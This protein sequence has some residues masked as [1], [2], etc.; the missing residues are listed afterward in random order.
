MSSLT[1]TL[2]IAC[3]PEELWAALTEGE[4]TRHWYMSA[5][6]E[7]SFET[8]APIRYMAR[9]QPGSEEYSDPEPVV[10]EA[11]EPMKAAIVGR[12]LENQ[13][14]ALLRYSFRFTDLDEGESTVSWRLS[15][16]ADSTNVVRLD[17]EHELPEGC[18]QTRA[19]AQ[20]CWPMMLSGLKTWLE[21]SK[22]LRLRG[23]AG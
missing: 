19:R 14:E 13:P 17:L 2:Y 12:I 5:R 11:P 3:H 10:G 6:V 4:Q 23:V 18:E 8:E 7:S 22:A 15:T 16:P 20:M 21:T 9:V 1:H